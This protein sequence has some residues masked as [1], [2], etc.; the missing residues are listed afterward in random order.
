MC[1]GQRKL[2][3][4][5]R[6]R[7]KGKAMRR[8]YQRDASPDHELIVGAQVI[9]IVEALGAPSRPRIASETVIAVDDEVREQAAIAR[10]RSAA[11]PV[12]IASIWSDRLASS[13]A[14]LRK[15]QRDTQA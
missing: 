9:V 12:W 13:S 7:V 6:G 10:C 3:L 1:T 5:A 2:G 11:V 8:G 15:V 4:L 14:T